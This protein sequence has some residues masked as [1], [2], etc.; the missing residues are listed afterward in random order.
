VIRLRMTFGRSGSHA[1]D[2]GTREVVLNN[3]SMSAVR[4]RLA[5]S[6][7]F[8]RPEEC[9]SPRAYKLELSDE[10]NT[11]RTAA[12]VAIALCNEPEEARRVARLKLNDPRP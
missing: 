11:N 2:S 1:G 7:P 6:P 5:P 8:A 4:V 10:K 3:A 9:D 12:G